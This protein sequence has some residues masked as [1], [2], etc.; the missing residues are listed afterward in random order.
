MAK[1]A[2]AV[3]IVVA[4]K[5]DESGLICIYPRCV[6]AGHCLGH[7]RSTGATILTPDMSYHR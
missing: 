3:A 1:A 6:A 2:K 5:A 7:D 4:P